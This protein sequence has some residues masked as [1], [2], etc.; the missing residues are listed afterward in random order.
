MSGKREKS[1]LEKLMC[2]K[3]VPTGKGREPYTYETT[4]RDY[5]I[6]FKIIN[7]EIFGGRLPPI[8]RVEIKW[9]RGCFAAYTY[10]ASS[11]RKKSTLLLNKK[12]RSKKFFVEMMAHEL[13][14]H[15][16][17]MYDEPMGHGPSFERWTKI[18][19]KK[20]LR[21]GKAHV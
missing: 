3:D 16:Q 5:L 11:K 14:H 15:Y 21:L 17:F 4:E 6:W 1:K 13:V 7:K 18:F 8:D 2:E 10:Q 20:G 19:N 12:Y 9:R